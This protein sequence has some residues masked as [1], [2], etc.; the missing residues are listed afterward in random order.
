MEYI[1]ASDESGASFDDNIE[2]MSNFYPS[3]E[4]R[5]GP[6]KE[7]VGMSVSERRFLLAHMHDNNLIKGVFTKDGAMNL[8]LTYQGHSWLQEYRDNTKLKQAFRWVGR[9]LDKLFSSIVLP[10]IAAVVT[11]L[12]MKYFG[13]SID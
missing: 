9:Q 2:K 6:T 1:E 5:E 13:I 11:V 4:P 8:H 7:K 3:M 12:V 10:V